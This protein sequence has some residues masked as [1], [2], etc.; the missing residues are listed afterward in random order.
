MTLILG[1]D[2]CSRWTNVGLLEN[3]KLLGE[4]NMNIGRKQASILPGLVEELFECC[5]RK[6]KQLD[7]IAVTSGPGYFTGIRIGMTYAASF[8]EALDIT[9]I[10]VSSLETLVPI[11]HPG[12]QPALSVIPNGKKRVFGVIYEV[13]GENYQGF[14]SSPSIYYPEQL[15]EYIRKLGTDIP[16]YTSEPDI[17]ENILSDTGLK[18]FVFSISSGL[19]VSMKGYSKLAEASSPALV[20]PVYL[21]PPQTG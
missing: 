20:S 10:P 3:G 1:I 12:N 16:C 7:S 15:T 18:N 2:S 4:T 5:Q 8:A 17:A 11:S 19:N 13:T 21:A 14:F 6:Y 9:L